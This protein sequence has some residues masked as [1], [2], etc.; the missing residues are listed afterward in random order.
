MWVSHFPRLSLFSPF[1]GSYN[2]SFAFSLLV[3]FIAISQVL[4]WA[5]LI[6]HVF[7]YFSTYSRSNCACFPFYMFFT[8]LTKIQVLQCV[9]YFT[10]F[11]LSVHIPSHTVFVSHFPCFSVFLPKSSFYSVYFSYLK[12]LTTVQVPK[13]VFLIYKV[14]HCF[15]PYSMSY[16]VCN[17]FQ[18]FFRVSRHISFPTMFIL[19]LV[20]QFSHRILGLTMC[21]FH[22]HVFSVSHL[23]PGH[24][25][26]VSHFAPFW[27]FSPK[28]RYYSLY[29]SIFYI[30]H[31]FS[32]HFRA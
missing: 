11:T 25:V 20:C 28:S 14:F 30:L 16:S 15:L 5:C 29:F 22:F 4:Q 10:F 2:L 17:S 18:I 23:I 1:S 6:F 31:C 8:F 27:V 21:N 32:P 3:S 19:F 12:F 9:S 13:Y 7:Q 24:T 26:F